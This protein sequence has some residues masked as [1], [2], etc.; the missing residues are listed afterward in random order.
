[1]RKH[2]DHRKTA[3]RIGMAVSVLLI[4]VGIA[5]IISYVVQGNRAKQTTRELQEAA[6][7]P[8][9]I[10]VQESERPS[11]AAGDATAA[12]LTAATPA[13]GPEETPVTEEMTVPSAEGKLLPVE[14]P[15]G[16]KVNERIRKARKKSQYVMGWLTMDDLDEPVVQKDNNFFLNHDASGLHNINGAIFMDEGTK[17]LTR[18]Y[19]IFLYG[20]NMKSGAMFGNLRKYRKAEYCLA[21]RVFTFETLYEKGKYEIFAVTMIRVTPGLSGYVDLW[22]LESEDRETRREAIAQIRKNSRFYST[23]KVS[24]EDQLVLLITCEGDDDQRLV[25]AAKRIG[26]AG[27]DPADP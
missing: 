6:E 15:E 24:E 16:L 12:D 4:A 8:S 25:V 19:T 7:D 3:I 1:M 26:N 14:Y 22:N 17:L 18:P 13:S 10:S 27:D 5:G 11:G 9:D 2:D 23:L 21:H 20:H